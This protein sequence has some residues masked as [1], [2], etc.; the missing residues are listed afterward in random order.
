MPVLTV[1]GTFAVG[2]KAWETTVFPSASV[3]KLW[4]Y[5]NV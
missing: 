1:L 4:K 3:V 5:V 2:T